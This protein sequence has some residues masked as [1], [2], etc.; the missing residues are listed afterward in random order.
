MGRA[1]ATCL[2]RPPLPIAKLE[3]LYLEYHDL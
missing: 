3:R 1:F 2:I